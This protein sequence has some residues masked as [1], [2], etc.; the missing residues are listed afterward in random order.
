MKDDKD[1]VFA[2]VESG[3]CVAPVSVK[4]TLAQPPKIFSP[5]NAYDGFSSS[6][7]PY[8]VSFHD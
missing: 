3:V 8:E 1:V 2:K 6:P 4:V 7:E 5:T